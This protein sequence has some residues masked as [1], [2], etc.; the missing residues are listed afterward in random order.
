MEGQGWS[1]VL[2]LSEAQSLYTVARAF[3]I[4]SKQGFASSHC[5]G[6]RGPAQRSP[7]RQRELTQTRS[8][9]SFLVMRSPN[10]PLLVDAP[11]VGHCRV[12]GHSVVI[13]RTL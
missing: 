5:E 11:G 12:A 7:S 4:S 6:P 8:S 9:D 2:S 1:K 3:L 10:I 13:S